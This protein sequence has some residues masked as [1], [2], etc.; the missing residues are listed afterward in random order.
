M[1]SWIKH[2][3]KKYIAL[4]TAIT[5]G[6]VNSLN[7]M[8]TLRQLLIVVIPFGLGWA[9]IAFAHVIGPWVDTLLSLGPH[10]IDSAG[11]IRWRRIW[12]SV[13]CGLIITYAIIK[14][15]YNRYKLHQE[16]KRSKE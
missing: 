2:L 14:F 11:K 5:L 3:G 9:F 7:Q 4:D 10:D 6:L 13:L 1:I 12:S 8:K 15:S 16:N